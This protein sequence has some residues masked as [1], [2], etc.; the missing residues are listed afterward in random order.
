[1]DNYSYGVKERKKNREK[2]THDFLNGAISTTHKPLSGKWFTLIELLI[3]V[4]IIAILAGILLPALQKARD[5]T[6]RISCINNLKQI[7]SGLQLY[8]NDNN[9]FN[10][11]VILSATTSDL[12]L[13]IPAF[14]LGEI[15]EI[16]RTKFDNKYYS[17]QSF[18][19]FR[20]PSDKGRR[21]GDLMQSN[22][23]MNGI[24]ALTS[25]S[26]YGMDKRRLSSIHNPSKVMLIGD[27]RGNLYV[28]S[29]TSARMCNISPGLS[30][31]EE[32]EETNRHIGNTINYIFADMHA[33]GKFSKDI[34]TEVILGANSIFFDRTQKY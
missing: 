32:V 28:N 9:D 14:C 13:S 7:S 20:C 19:F 16:S 8:Y 30:T 2:H 18:K 31:S 27:G 21:P 24:S 5:T 12:W 10:P 3:V 17:T 22:Y 25:S 29:N 33:E 34:K 26:A 6:K 23:G 1:M 4:S 11:G 15:D